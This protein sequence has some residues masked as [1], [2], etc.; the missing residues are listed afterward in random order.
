MA[1]VE[2]SELD[3]VCKEHNTLQQKLTEDLAHALGSVIPVA[4]KDSIIVVF[5][6]MSVL[7]LFGW[8][9]FFLLVI[10]GIAPM[11]Y[12]VPSTAKSLKQLSDKIWDKVKLLQ[13]INTNYYNHLRLLQ[14]TGTT[15]NE[16]VRHDEVSGELSKLYTENAK[17]RMALNS[18]PRTVCQFLCVLSVLYVTVIFENGSVVDGIL[19]TTCVLATFLSLTFVLQQVFAVTEQKGKLVQLADILSLPPRPSGVRSVLDAR[20]IRVD[21]LKVEYP[22]GTSLFSE[23]LFFALEAGQ[24]VVLVGSSGSGKSTCLEVLS[25]RGTGM[26]SGS[27][28]FLTGEGWVSLLDTDLES[29]T[30]TFITVPQ[31]ADLF[32][33]RSVEEN[34][35][36]RITP[37][38]EHHRKALIAEA[39]EAVG[40]QGFEEKEAA[41][42]SGGQKKR[43]QTATALVGMLIATLEGRRVVLILDEAA[44][45]LDSLT[46]RQFVV[47][48]ESIRKKNGGITIWAS[49]ADALNPSY[50]TALVFRSDGKGLIEQG[51]VNDLRMKENSAYAQVLLSPK[52]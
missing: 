34:V 41:N 11:M 22:N 20:A 15:R 1:K 2:P 5:W 40:L 21:N 33:D 18:A 32:W 50:A 27:I 10:F 49:H 47:N 28:Q 16:I 48:I 12:L 24:S 17:K 6:V 45:S 51:R 8:K 52:L 26:W 19:A 46:A 39:L 23:G 14:D 29:Y 43:V 9:S 31:E 37:E 4:I 44:S 3:K 38:L 42:L 25:R 7:V 13:G 35:G 36:L 30:R